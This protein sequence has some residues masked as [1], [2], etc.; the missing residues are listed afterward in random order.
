WMSITLDMVRI[1]PAMRSRAN[2]NWHHLAAGK[3]HAGRRVGRDH[4]HDFNLSRLDRPRTLGC[5]VGRDV[6]RAG[7][8]ETAARAWPDLELAIARRGRGEA[9]YRAMQPVGN[10][11]EGVV[12]ERGHLAGID[13]AVR[14]QAVPALPDGGRP[15]RYGVEPRWAFSLVEQMKGSII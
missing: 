7:M 14:P 1:R 11:P 9:A 5:S 6:P 10:S 12:V 13:R 15:H 4:N 2:L 8:G 3:G